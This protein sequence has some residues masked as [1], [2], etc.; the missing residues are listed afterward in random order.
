MIHKYGFPFRPRSRAREKNVRY[1]I[2]R[3]TFEDEYDDE[4]DYGAYD[5]EHVSNDENNK[6]PIATICVSSKKDYF[7]EKIVKTVTDRKIS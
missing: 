1:E 6:Y 2:A 5:D 7:S 3:K 4:D